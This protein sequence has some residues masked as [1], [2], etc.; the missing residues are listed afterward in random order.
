MSASVLQQALHRA[1]THP[2]T[3][4]AKGPIKDLWWTARGRGLSNPPLPAHVR[5]L[6]FVCKGNICRSPFAAVRARQLLLDRNVT[7]VTCDSAGIETTQ[8][9]RPPREACHAAA[10]FGV[11]LDA[12]QPVQLTSKIVARYDLTIVMEAEQ[13]SALRR[14]YPEQADRIVLLP[15]LHDSAAGYARFNIA[16]PFGQPLAA[17]QRCY[18]HTDEALGELIRLVTADRSAG[19]QRE[20]HR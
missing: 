7:D 14:S 19:S 3:M 11:A 2:L 13:F 17:F 5:S 8:A 9:A 12:H 16:D 6:L 15:L 18:C 20:G 1:L 10:H 4:A